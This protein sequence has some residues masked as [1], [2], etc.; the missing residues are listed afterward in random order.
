MGYSAIGQGVKPNNLSLRAIN[1]IIR[2]RHPR[3]IDGF[4]LNFFVLSNFLLPMIDL[5]QVDP[6]FEP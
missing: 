3:S 1:R 6:S 2:K 5:S 4:S